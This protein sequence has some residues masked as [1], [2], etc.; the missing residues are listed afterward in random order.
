MR[1]LELAAGIRLW[2]STDDMVET[3]TQQIGEVT[4]VEMSG[5]LHLGNSLMYAENVIHRL[6]DGGTRKLVIDLT[7]LEHLDSSGLGM[8]ISCSGRM[9]KSGGRM[10][11]AGARPVVAQIFEIA[12][13]GRILRFD[14][15]LESACHK[16]SAESA[17]G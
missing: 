15:D 14:A 3:K 17:A 8:L 16:L 13:A 5:S 9:D 11:V 10:R 7:R 1:I 2:R 12:H 6:I 4:V